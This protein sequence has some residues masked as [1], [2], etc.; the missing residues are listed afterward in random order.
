MV[1]DDYLDDSYVAGAA[2]QGEQPSSGSKRR[3]AAALREAGLSKRIDTGRG[4]EMLKRM[5]A[6]PTFPIL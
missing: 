2:P 5:G 1:E 4:F 6:L 3:T